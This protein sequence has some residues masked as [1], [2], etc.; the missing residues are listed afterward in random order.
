MAEY[1]LAIA[2]SRSRGNQKIAE[3]QAEKVLEAD[4]MTILV[5]KLV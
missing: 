2:T 4:D 3:E 5:S 1:L